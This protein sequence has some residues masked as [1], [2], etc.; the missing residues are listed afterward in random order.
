MLD[1]EGGS[2]AVESLFNRDP[3]RRRHRQRDQHD[4]EEAEFEALQETAST[5]IANMDAWRSERLRGGNTQQPPT[6]Y[7][8]LPTLTGPPVR[9]DSV[10][11]SAGVGGGVSAQVNQIASLLHTNL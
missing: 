6:V 7:P 4:L 5:I 3:A 9:F 11:L 8:T 10:D 1:H 2:E